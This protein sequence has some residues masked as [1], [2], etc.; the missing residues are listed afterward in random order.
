[1]FDYSDIRDSFPKISTSAI[2]EYP[3]PDPGTRYLFDEIPATASNVVA[4]YSMRRVNILYTGPVVRIRNSVTLAEADFY[5]DENQTYLKNS[6]DMSF[7][8]WSNGQA[9]LATRWYDQSGNGNFLYQASQAPKFTTQNGKY[10]LFFDNPAVFTITR[11]SMLS[12]AP[13]YGQQISLIHKPTAVTSGK[14]GDI[15]NPGSVVSYTTTQSITTNPIM[16][17]YND[18]ILNGSV[19]LN[20]WSTFTAYAGS[21]FGPVNILCNT[22]QNIADV[23]YAGYLF[24]LGFFNG[25]TFSDTAERG[26]YNNQSPL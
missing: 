1:M 10:V 11:Y 4:M 26:E 22:T 15:L 6:D 19:P 8:T 23:V 13:L 2:I 16:T 20:A 9:C 17:K 12:S 24:E 5:T 7:S 21:Q 14:R 3:P 25:T 18:N